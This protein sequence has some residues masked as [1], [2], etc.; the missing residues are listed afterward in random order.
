LTRDRWFGASGLRVPQIAVEGEHSLSL[1]DA[2]VLEN[3]DDTAALRAAHETGRPVVV[4][5]G[6]PE[7]VVA[8]LARP[9]VA[10]VLVPPG[11]RDLLE[12]DLVEL[13]YGA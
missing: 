8:A 1:D 7:A 9:E 6:T 13:T 12:L 10:C 3:V 11:K 4:R 2:L 5:A